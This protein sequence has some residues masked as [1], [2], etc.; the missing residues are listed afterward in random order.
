MLLLR[1]GGGRCESGEQ[2]AP[3]D[4]DKRSWEGLSTNQHVGLGGWFRKG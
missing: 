2:G 4:R 1:V 3:G